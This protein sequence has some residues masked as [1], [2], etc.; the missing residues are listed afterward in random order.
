MSRL[1]EKKLEQYLP[2]GPITSLRGVET[3][4]G[5][6]AEA[7]SGDDV[8]GDPEFGLYYT[9]GE[10]DT[11]VT[12]D[13]SED[14]RYLVTIRIDLTTSELGPDDVEVRV[15]PLSPDLVSELGFARYPWGRGIDHSITRRGAKGGS[16]A[17]TVTTYCIECL[18]RW[19]N[20]DGR[21][22]AIGE[23]AETHPDGWIIQ[24]LQRLGNDAAIQDRIESQVAQR[25]TTAGRVVATVQLKL[26]PDE[27]DRNPTGESTGWFYP[28][29]VHVLNTGMKARKDQKLAEKNTDVPSSG[30][31]VCLVT[32]DENEVFGTAEDPLAFFTVQHAEKFDELKRANAWRSH[33]VSSD[34]ALLIQSGSSLLE[35]CRTTRNGLSVY[36]LPYFVEVNNQRAEALYHSL[37]RLQDRSSSELNNHPMLELLEG[38]EEAGTEEDIEALRFYVISL[39]NDSGDINVIHEVPDVSIYWPRQVA[40]AHDAVLNK[41]S[42]FG[43]SGF[44]RTDNW[45][46]ITHR[47][48]TVRAL[49]SIVSG[50]YAW[51]TMPQMAGDDGAMAD[52]LAEWLTY[53]L[54]TGNSV[55]VDKLLDGYVDRIEQERREDDENRIPVNHIKTQFAQL[56]ALAQADM[57]DTA[58]DT[59]YQTQPMTIDDHDL[60]SRAEV[61]GDGNLSRL[62]ARKYRLDKFLSDRGALRENPDRKGAFL[63]GVLIGMVSHHQSSNRD[64][65]RTVIDQYPPDQI[66]TDRLVNVWPDLVHRCRVYAAEVNWAG[67]TLF[68]ELLD[69]Q[70][71]VFEYPDEWTIPLR[72]IRFF[73]AMGVAYGQRADAR[74]KELVA[75]IEDAENSTGDHV[76]AEEP[77]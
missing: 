44:E 65:N 12:D 76:E 63:T 21:E 45:E 5:A 37:A 43:L 70:T 59:D 8:G 47:T 50:R 24:A 49:N 25:Y 61:A 67:E 16:D 22:T 30:D 66:T 56:E 68:P 11:F 2:D 33:P 71:D 4:Y 57:L 58:D 42:A 36:T 10:L 38:V 14:D 19:T 28:G 77:A 74:A 53:Q 73:Y 51:G 62:N 72:E 20:A 1:A 31:G 9:P 55:P 18:Q 27:L 48:D 6:L 29:R 75:T 41:S 17:G 7:A 35:T 64:M 13:P 69:Y 54:L 52:D 60:P 34:V 3:L 46:P 39:R 23:I 15:D 32:G 26:N 40:I